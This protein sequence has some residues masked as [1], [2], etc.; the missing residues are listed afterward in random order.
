M[1]VPA[2]C[3]SGREVAIELNIGVFHTGA[4]TLLFVASLRGLSLPVTGE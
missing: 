2:L 1:R 3:K 4:G